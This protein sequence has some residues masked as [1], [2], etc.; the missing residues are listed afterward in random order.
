MLSE[1]TYISAFNV[2]TTRHIEVRKTTDIS[3]DGAVVS[4]THWRGVL[5]PHD[6]Q[7]EA[8]LGDEP[9]YLALAETAWADVPVSA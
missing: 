2:L 6:P 7:A 9:F 5:A 4:T 3:R 8:V 1:Q